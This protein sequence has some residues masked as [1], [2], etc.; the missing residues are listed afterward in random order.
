MGGFHLGKSFIRGSISAV[1]AGLIAWVIFRVIP[2]PIS[3]VVLSGCAV[4]FGGIAG[5]ILIR[6]EL[7]LL[8]SL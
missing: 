8:I 6:R 7:R 1:I 3:D 4:I 2:I 5:A